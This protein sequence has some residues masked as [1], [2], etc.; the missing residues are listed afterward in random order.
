MKVM[1]A[2]PVAD[3]QQPMTT[4]DVVSKVLYLYQGKPPSQESR[5]NHFLKNIGILR[6]FTRAETSTKMTLREQFAGEQESIAALV[7]LVDELKRKIED[8]KREFEEFKKLQQEEY[9]R[10]CEQVMRLSSPG[11]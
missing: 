6:S 11:N 2:E 4:A 7:E 8:S 5:K 9:N 1:Q 3:E 10:L